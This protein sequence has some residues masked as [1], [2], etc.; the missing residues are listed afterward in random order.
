MPA[1]LITQIHTPSRAHSSYAFPTEEES[2]YGLF[3]VSNLISLMKTVRFWSISQRYDSTARKT[4]HKQITLP[5]SFDSANSKL[6]RATSGVFWMPTPGIS[7]QIWVLNPSNWLMLHLQEANNRHSNPNLSQGWGLHLIQQRCI[8]GYFRKQ[9]PFKWKTKVTAPLL[10]ALSW[11]KWLYLPSSK[12]PQNF[13]KAPRKLPHFNTNS[14]SPPSVRKRWDIKSSNL[15]YMIYDW[16]YDPQSYLSAPG[17]C[18]ADRLWLE[19][20]SVHQAYR[21]QQ[22]TWC[23]FGQQ[24]LVGVASVF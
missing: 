14:S 22:E 11:E 13:T 1:L 4:I 18:L 2:S 15:H 16:G 20:S 19:S 10:R 21:P 7:Q 5:E 3:G 23:A 24:S 6:S 8:W 12:W 9:N 17:S